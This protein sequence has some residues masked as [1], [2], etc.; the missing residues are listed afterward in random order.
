MANL[1]YLMDW[2]LDKIEYPLK[3]N[4]RYQ[5]GESSSVYVVFNNVT[6][7]T[8]IG[9]TKNIKN[10]IR[11]LETSSGVNLDLL[12]AIDLQEDYDEKA[13]LIELML[14]DFYKNKRGVGEWF[15]LNVKDVIQIR[16]LFYF[17][18]GEMVYDNLK[19]INEKLKTKI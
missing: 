7:L 18:Y 6:N 2:Y 13:G 4:Q 8:K 5:D 14:H 1:N 15:N 11:S 17:I 19:E 12:L 10:R 9:I 16:T 3:E